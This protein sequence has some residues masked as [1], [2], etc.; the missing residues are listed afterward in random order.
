MFDA[1]V[2]RVHRFESARSSSR[3]RSR[4]FV[5]DLQILET[6]EVLSPPTI[7]GTPVLTALGATSA[8]ITWGA[9]SDNVPVTSYSVYWIYTTGHSGRGGGFT[10]RTVLEATTNG[11][12][13]TATISGLTRNST[14]ALY[15]KRPTPLAIRAATRARSP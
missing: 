7:P 15:V 2:K 8:T 5:A 11:S 6:R 14:Y 9:S 1:R 13:T 4:R 3:R 12:T 10:T